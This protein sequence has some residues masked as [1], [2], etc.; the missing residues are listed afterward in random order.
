[1]E[2]RKLGNTGVEMTVLGFGC[3]SVWGKKLITDAEAQELF[4]LAYQQ[5]IRYFDTGY[6]YDHAEA[7]IGQILKTSQVVKREDIVISTKVGT[8]IKDGKYVHDFSPE[9]VMQSVRGSL[10]KMGLDYVDLLLVHGPGIRELTPE[11]MAALQEVKTRGLTKALGINTFDTA[12]L[13]YVRDTKCFDFVMP[14]YNI[15]RQDREPLLKELYE[16]GIGII[17]GAPLAESLY[18][19]RVFRIRKLKDVWYLARALKNHRGK[20]LQGR[21]YRFVN[22]VPGMTGAQ[23]VLRYVLDN[24]YVTTAVFGCTTP[25]HLIE[26]AMAANLTLP[27]EVRTMIQTAEK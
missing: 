5:G 6:S 9:W 1:M 27:R 24:P 17:A 10:E 7:R 3:A 4:E 21:K 22:H 11:Y 19:D 18:T 2:K 26:N 14:D 12:V 20:L 25:S 23:V 16:N 8:V 15:M 13:E